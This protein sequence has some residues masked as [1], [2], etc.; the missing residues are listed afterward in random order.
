M[1]LGEDDDDDKG[2]VGKGK[3]NGSNGSSDDEEV[4]ERVGQ[5][6]RV[7]REHEM[8]FL[9]QTHAATQPATNGGAQATTCHELFSA[10]WSI[11]ACRA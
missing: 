10:V 5:W 1:C 4:V 7:E 6:L 8:I 3:S 11:L 9:A 2:E